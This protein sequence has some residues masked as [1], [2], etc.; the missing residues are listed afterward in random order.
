MR[1]IME[2]L[3]YKQSF[4]GPT[5]MPVLTSAC[6]NPI[7]RMHLYYAQELLRGTHLHRPAIVFGEAGGVNPAQT[8]TAPPLLPLPP[9]IS[10]ICK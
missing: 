10:H 2:N 6:L 7:L 1:H 5:P 4:S 3:R 8:L 9:S